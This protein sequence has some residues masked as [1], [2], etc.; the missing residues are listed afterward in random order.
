MADSLGKKNITWESVKVKSDDGFTLTVFHLTG[1][2]NGPWTTS[3]SSVVF[4]SGLGGDSREFTATLPMSGEKPM[5]YQL[6]ALGYDVWLANNSA[7]LYSKEHDKY[8]ADDREY[9]DMDWQKYGIY[10]TPAVVTEIQKRNGGKK[11]GYIGHSQGT[12]QVLA[13]M[14]IIPEWYDKNISTAVLLGPCVIPNEKY[15]HAYSKESWD[16]LN[17]HEIWAIGNSEGPSWDDNLAL[18]NAEGPQELKDIMNAVKD[19]VDVPVQAV[20]AFAQTSHSK[21]FMRYNPNWFEEENPKAPLM[22]YGLVREMK[23]AMFVGLWDNTCP[24]TYAQQMYENFGGEK[25]VTD[26]IVHPMHGHVPWGFANSSWFMDKL[27][28]ALDRNTN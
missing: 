18:I 10:D 16:F 7:A 1:D 17:E 3:K 20:A 8:T 13:G 15:F 2:E 14:G 24:V 9:W 23:V 22:D 21:R 4:T 26:W 12:S 25:T 11:V 28:T 5:A 6:G 27:T 19:M